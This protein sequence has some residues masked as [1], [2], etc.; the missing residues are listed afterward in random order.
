[1]GARFDAWIERENEFKHP[2]TNQAS[3]MA[4][5]LDD[6]RIENGFLIND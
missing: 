3:K 1:M 6:L 4:P 5:F 2:K